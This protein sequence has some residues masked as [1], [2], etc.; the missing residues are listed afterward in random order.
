[1]TFSGRASAPVRRVLKDPWA[2]T[3]VSESGRLSEADRL[4]L[5][6]QRMGYRIGGKASPAP[7]EWRRPL[8]ALF[9]T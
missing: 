8:A 7:A 2:A 9:R 5:H 4:A 3:C 1:M 6:R